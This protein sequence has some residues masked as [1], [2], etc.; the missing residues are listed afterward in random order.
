MD[1]LEQLKADVLGAADITG[2]GKVRRV[3][4]EF[5]AG[6]E[7]VE[8]AFFPANKTGPPNRVWREG[9]PRGNT[10]FCRFGTILV[11]RERKPSLLE[12]AEEASMLM[13]EMQAG[14]RRGNWAA[15]DGAL[16]ALTA[17]IKEERE[18]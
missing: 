15:F 2:H 16:D 5:I 12:A 9:W 10:D 7:V 11:P 13:R 4:N 1:V 3:L 18:R 8:A 17:A 14:R 6:Y